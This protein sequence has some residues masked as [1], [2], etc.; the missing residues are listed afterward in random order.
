MGETTTRVLLVAILVSFFAFGL[1][2]DFDVGAHQ[3]HAAEVGVERSDPIPHVDEI[4]AL[5]L[6]WA[7]LLALGWSR[8]RLRESND[9]RLVNDNVGLVHPRMEATGPSLAFQLFFPMLA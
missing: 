7:G 4:C 2:H 8:K 1:A 6:I 5:T 3:S 9:V